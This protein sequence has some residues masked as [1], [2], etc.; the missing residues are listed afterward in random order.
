MAD[1]MQK[2]VGFAAS[3]TTL[4][5]VFYLAL[6]MGE[7]VSSALQV[8]ESDDFAGVT[9]GAESMGKAFPCIKSL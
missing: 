9:I 6:G 5:T 4:V 2:F 3:L 7:E 1:D 8:N